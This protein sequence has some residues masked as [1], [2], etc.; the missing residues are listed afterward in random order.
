MKIQKRWIVVFTI[1]VLTA[2]I[3]LTGCKKDQP[4]TEDHSAHDHDAGETGEVA[5]AQKTCPIMDKPIDEKISIEYKGK[6]VYLCCQMCES[7]FNKEPEKYISKLP[8]F[9]E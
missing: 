6:K 5:I 7:K 2:A 8:Q 3:A 1:V 4:K 9:Q